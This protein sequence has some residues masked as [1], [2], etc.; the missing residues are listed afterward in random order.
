MIESIV[1]TLKTMAKWARE[2]KI[3]CFVV[4]TLLVAIAL[5]LGLGLGLGLPTNE[6]NESETTTIIV[7]P[8]VTPPVAAAAPTVF[9][10]SISTQKSRFAP[11][12]KKFR[13][14]SALNPQIVIDRFFNPSGGPSNLFGILKQIDARV[15]GIN[16]RLNTQFKT[17]MA[18]TPTN[19]TLSTWGLNTTMFAQCSETW[20]GPQGQTTTEGFD[21][22][23]IK[24]PNFYLFE[25]GGESRVAAI[26]HNFN[27]T[28]GPD[29]VR[30]WY[31]VGCINRNGSHG[32][33]EIIARPKDGIFEMTAAGGGL[34]FCGAQ[35]KS[36]N[37][38]LNITGSEDMGSCSDIET[39]CVS[40]Q[41][42]SQ[43]A[44]CTGSINT[45]Q[46][47]PIGRMPYNITGVGCIHPP[48]NDGPSKYPASG[49]NVYLTGTGLDDTFFGPSVPTV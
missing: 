25:G 48:C 22:W 39:V 14:Q 37:M 10:I 35:L 33:V 31:S 44:N 26:L 47:R 8:Y 11:L 16:G 5:G 23:A 43:T 3:G 6:A 1:S 42:L 49:P 41:D 36:N 21:Q 17:C 19:Y 46:L 12:S 40:A 38:T 4:T 13:V 32:V 20:Q 34:G 24:G 15:Q 7:L 30:V 45:F 27:A 29:L 28:G 18:A 9:V 2:D